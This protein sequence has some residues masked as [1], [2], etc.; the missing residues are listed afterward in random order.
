MTTNIIA[1]NQT[2]SKLNL[3]QPVPTIIIIRTF[4]RK[5]EWMIEVVFEGGV[6]AITSATADEVG[7][8][9]SGLYD[10]GWKITPSIFSNGFNAKPPIEDDWGMLF[11]SSAGLW[12]DDLGLAEVQL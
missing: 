2:L 7:T 4:E 11:A 6:K 10:R 3:W 5:S 12:P 8:I 9:E 1:T